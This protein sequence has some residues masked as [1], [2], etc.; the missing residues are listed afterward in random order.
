VFLVFY[1]CK[2]KTVLKIMTRLNKEEKKIKEKKKRG[3]GR[4][5]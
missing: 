3:E 4:M 2:L 1:F 5:L